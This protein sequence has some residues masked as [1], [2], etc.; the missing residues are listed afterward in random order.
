M[1]PRISLVTLGADDLQ[2][3]LV[4]LNPQFDIAD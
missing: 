4:L 2:R 1:K 3:S